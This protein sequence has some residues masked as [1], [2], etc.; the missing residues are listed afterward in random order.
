VLKDG[1]PPTYYMVCTGGSFG[2]RR[3]YDL[4]L[5]ESTGQSV[6]PAGKPAWAAN[7]SRNWAPEMHRVGD[8]YVVY[9]TSVNGENVLSIGATSSDSPLGPYTDRGSPLVEHAQGVIDS[10]YFRDTDGKHY[11]TYKIDGNS[12]GQPTPIYIRELAPDGMSFAEGSSQ[13][14]ILTNQSATW[15]GGVVE[16]QW[17]IERDGTYFLFYSGNVYDHRYRTGVARAQNVLGPYTKHG[18]PILTNNDDWV[19]PGHGSVIPVGDDFY[20]IY[21]A[22]PENGA[23]QHASDEG[24]HVL[25]DKINFED[26]WPVIADGSPSTTVQ[27]RPTE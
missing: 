17:L 15:E 9:Y 16:A 21:H 12:V 2:I 26:N 18:D 14:E 25:L 22:W 20:F 27:P 5:W 23:G 3:S 6:I 24:R 7:G 8:K 11:L 13:V 4:V 1:T 19:G 10:H